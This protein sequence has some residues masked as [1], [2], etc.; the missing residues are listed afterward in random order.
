MFVVEGESRG[1]VICNGFLFTAPITYVW[2]DMH[3]VNER[4]M[5]LCKCCQQVFCAWL[6]VLETCLLHCYLWRS[7]GY[8]RGWGGLTFFCSRLV[9]HPGTGV[10]LS[11]TCPLIWTSKNVFLLNTLRLSLFQVSHYLFCPRNSWCLTLSWVSHC[12]Y[13]EMLSANGNANQQKFIKNY[14]AFFIFL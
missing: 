7:W 10:L 11:R 9:L 3:T 8:L 12:L 2:I 5:H 1:G 4:H 13:M 14:S 6:R